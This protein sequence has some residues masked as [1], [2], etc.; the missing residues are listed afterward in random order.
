MHQHLLLFCCA[1]TWHDCPS[2]RSLGISQDSSR[3]D[4]QADSIANRF[5]SILEKNPQRGTALDKV[6]AFHL[7]RGSWIAMLTLER[8]IELRQIQTTIPLGWMGLL[9]SQRRGDQK[10][11]SHSR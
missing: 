3:D 5:L 1:F 11:I 7:Q 8:K 9:E 10:A 6:F 4:K 2:T